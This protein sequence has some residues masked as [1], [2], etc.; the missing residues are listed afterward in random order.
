MTARRPSLAE[1]APRLAETALANVTRE[2]PSF[3]AHVVQGPDDV[4]RP[5]LL[6]PSFYGAYDWHSAVH[7]HWLLV[8]LL[9]E[10]PDRIDAARV[11]TVL[12]AHLAPE[13]LG[14]EA[15]YLS[16]W[17]G[18]E[19]PYGWAWLL[20]LAAAC[21]EP[22][23]DV[24]ITAWGRALR[25]VADVVAGLVIAWLPSASGPV[26]DGTHGSTAFAFGLVLDA[27]RGLRMPGLADAVTE[28]A[29][30]WF[31]PDRHAP[32]SWEPSGEDF[33]SP[34][35]SEADL[36]RRLLAGPDFARWLDGFLPGLG[37]GEP[38]S[39]LEPVAP[40]DRSDG[41]A[42]HL[43][44]LNLSRAAALRSIANALPAEDPRRPVLVRS[45]DRHLAA[46]V[47]ALAAG[48]YS[49]SHWLGTFAALALRG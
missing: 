35:L 31:L 47:R 33:L 45:A 43:D 37:A 32:A 42:G 29:T 10:H 36:V 20:A 30:R 23:A 28:A 14:V 48:E 40:P 5:R 49:S 19:R 18:F 38:R 3:V 12:T 4:S 41:R 22:H 17:P 34:S 9:R 16:A 39:L 15:A 24:R 6:H 2:F 26:R 1:L 7:M 44:G 8:R 21:A 11:R 27:A 25:P 46:G 13:P